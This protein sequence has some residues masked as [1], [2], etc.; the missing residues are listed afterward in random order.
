MHDNLKV[1]VA[2]MSQLYQINDINK[3]S[4]INLK[5]WKQPMEKKIVIYLAV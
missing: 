3:K 4:N 2:Q 5:A 1:R